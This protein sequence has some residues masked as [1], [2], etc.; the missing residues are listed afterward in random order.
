M[1]AF[2]N[3][4]YLFRVNLA[5]DV[6]RNNHKE[7]LKNLKEKIKEYN[8]NIAFEN[9]RRLSGYLNNLDTIFETITNS[10]P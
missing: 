5:M 4:D 7:S 10:F 1:T 3:A 2:D 6:L 9:A 8:K